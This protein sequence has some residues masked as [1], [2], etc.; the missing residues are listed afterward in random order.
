MKPMWII[1]LVAVALFSLAPHQVQADVSLGLSISDGEV[2]SFYLA[3]GG[4]YRVPERTLVVVH[5]TN[6]PDDEVP[7]VF[8]I[9]QRAR[10]SPDVIID[11]RLSGR[12]WMDI[13]LHYGLSPEIFY[14]PLAVAPG[15][16]DRKSTR[17][18]SSHQLISY[19]V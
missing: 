14:V 16:P 3:V 9:A 13:T 11:M 1:S 4:S 12:S 17:L 10:V 19:A 7:V 18:N 2:R 15:P 5:E 8:F 6:I